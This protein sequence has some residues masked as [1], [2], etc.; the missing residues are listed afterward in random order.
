MQQKTR[1]I[2]LPLLLVA[3]TAFANW[4]DGLKWGYLSGSWSTTKPAVTYT[5]VHNVVPLVRRGMGIL[6]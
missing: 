6:L 4:Q 1:Q 2:L 3:F 5:L